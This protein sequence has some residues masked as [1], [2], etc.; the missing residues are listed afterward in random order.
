MPAGA[1]C[2]P[3]L[4]DAAAYRERPQALPA[5]AALTRQTRPRPFSRI[6]AHPVQRLHVVLERGAAKQADL[7]HVRRAE[8]RLSALALDG[9]DH[10]RFFAAD[11]SAR[12]AAKMDRRD[13][14]GRIRL[15]RGDLALEDRAAAVIF[16]AEV[17]IDRLDADSPRRDQRA[18][19]KAMRIALQIV[20]VLECPR[21]ALVDVDRHQAR[22][23]L[24]RHQLPFA[25]GGEAGAAEAA[26][27]GIF[28]H[29]DDFG[30][31]F[32]SGDARRRQRVS[33]RGAVRCVIDVAGSDDTGCSLG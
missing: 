24:G 12:A 22:R 9:F 14:A 16:V 8:A 26:Q 27:A 18:F 3:G 1:R 25:A 33:A 11:V 13:R 7:R 30:G 15:E 32:F 23:G 21:L 5:V 10:R 29:R 2:T 20:A 28:H 4:L 19:E 31:L 17:N 6:V